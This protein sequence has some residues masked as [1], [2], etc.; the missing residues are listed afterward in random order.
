MNWRKTSGPGGFCKH[1]G[2]APFAYVDA[3]AWNDGAYYALNVA[4][5]DGL[6]PEQLVALPVAYFDGLHDTWAPIEGETRH[7]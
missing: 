1:C 7:L 3:A 4:C 6:T 5:L 2:V